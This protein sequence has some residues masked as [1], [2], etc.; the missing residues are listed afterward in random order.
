MHPVAVLAGGLGTRLRELSG[1]DVPKVLFSVNGRPF[2]DWKLSGLATAGVDEVVL[3]VGHQGS[4]IREHVGDGARFGLRVA[5][6]DDGPALRGT[7]GALRHALG[8][9]PETFWV[10]YGDSLLE[11]DLGAAERL[12]AASGCRALMTVLR[13]NDRWQ[14]SNVV[15]DGDLV[16]AYCKDPPP[17]GA[18]CIDYGMLLFERSAWSGLADDEPI[19]LADVLDPLVHARQVAAFEVTTRFHDI[20]TPDAVRET[21]AFLQH[22]PPNVR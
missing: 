1:A 16:T 5:Y 21:E 19:D 22:D 14:P 15:V 6:V 10:T 7:G 18:D 3:L 20:G 4:R 13:N 8:V 12:F 11:V 2:L 9:L 17:D